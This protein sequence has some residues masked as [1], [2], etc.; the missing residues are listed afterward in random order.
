MPMKRKYRRKSRKPRR[1]TR[2]K[3]TPKGKGGTFR[4]KVKKALMSMSETKN[5]GRALND[6]ITLGNF[7]SEWVQAH[8]V[9]PVNSSNFFQIKEGTGPNER[10]GNRVTFQSI[11][12]PMY[13]TNQTPESL[14]IRVIMTKRKANIEYLPNL[15]AYKWFINPL[16]ESEHFNQTAPWQADWPFN[17]ELGTVVK[18]RTF[19][20]DGSIDWG[21]GTAGF[22]G[23]RP[24]QFTG[25]RGIKKLEMGFKLGFRHYFIPE[26]VGQVHNTHQY[27]QFVFVWRIHNN[28]IPYEVNHNLE[29]VGNLQIKQFHKVYFKDV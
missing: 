1:T 26:T 11:R 12:I 3:Y 29:G 22:P 15:T 8:D 21:S 24:V 18:Q 25:N 2:R 20:L 6:Q 4:T 27:Q 16:G 13:I 9:F 23:H 10:I 17:K 19:T 14:R 28:T 7:E 5:V